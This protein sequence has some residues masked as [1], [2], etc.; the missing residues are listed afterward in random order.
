[1]AREAGGW[2]DG[3]CGHYGCILNVLPARHSHALI[4]L[5]TYLAV[6]GCRLLDSL[7]CKCYFKNQIVV[8]LFSRLPWLAT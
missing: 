1:M 2:T 8:R 7:K 4:Y 5:P 6:D 3:S